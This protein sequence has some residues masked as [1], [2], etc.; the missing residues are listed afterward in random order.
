MKEASLDRRRAGCC[1][2]SIASIC[3]RCSNSA[4]R[5]QP[6]RHCMML[7][8]LGRRGQAQVRAKEFAG[9]FLR[10]DEVL[11]RLNASRLFQHALSWC[12]FA[13]R[14]MCSCCSCRLPC[15]N[16]GR[17]AEPTDLCT[18]LLAGH[19]LVAK[20]VLLGNSCRSCF[21][22]EPVQACCEPICCM[23]Q[24]WLALLLCNRVMGCCLVRPQARLFFS[25][26]FLFFRLFF[27]V[28]LLTAG[29]R[30]SCRQCLLFVLVL[31]AA[32]WP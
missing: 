9:C 25:S 15:L 1:G 31:L 26:G 24:Q 20:D 3:N 17:A 10:L 27:R 22:A 13:C 6:T 29:L 8:H 23:G 28:A 12:S 2:G 16:N 14:C 7:A 30:P 18:A 19:C 5:L 32:T 21:L 11:C 4:Q